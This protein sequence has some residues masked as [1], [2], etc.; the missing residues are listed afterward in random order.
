VTVDGKSRGLT[1]SGVGC[2][3]VP[4]A[5]LVLV[6]VVYQLLGPK[7]EPEPKDDE[8][9]WEYY[10]MLVFFQFDCSMSGFPAPDSRAAALGYSCSDL[11]SVK[12]AACQLHD[13]RL[14][15]E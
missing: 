14:C 2:L 6:A 11:P 1:I 9:A 7:Y 8:P 10:N 3:L 13:W 15:H 12:A 4:L 5:V